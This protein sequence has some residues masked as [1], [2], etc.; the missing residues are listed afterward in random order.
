MPADPT[1]PECAR[2]RR[3][4]AIGL[5]VVMSLFPAIAVVCLAG[6]AWDHDVVGI[7]MCAGGLIAVSTLMALAWSMPLPP[8]P[9]EG[10]EGRR[11]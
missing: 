7:A 6:T 4:G 1:C 10:K 5:R 9:G 11:D 8:K 3:E 2:S